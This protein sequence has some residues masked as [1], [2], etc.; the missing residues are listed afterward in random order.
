MDGRRP[1][2]GS[3]EPLG[4]GPGEAG[5][6]A[7]ILVFVTV[8]IDL[9]GFGIVLPLLPFYATDLGAGPGEVGLIIASFSAMQFVFAPVWGRLSDRFGRRP[10][11]LVGL[12]GS[13][14]SYVIFGLAETVAVLLLSRVAGGVMGANVA[15]AQAYVADATTGERRARGMGMIGAAFGIGF[16]LGPAL[17]GV[18]SRWGYAVPGFA[19]AGLSLVAAAVATVALPES[20]PPERRVEGGARGTAALAAA[21]ERGR[22]LLQAV[23]RPALRDPIGAAFVGTLGFAAF[24]TAFPLLLQGPMGMSSVDAGWMFAFLGLVSATVQGG[25][26]GATV[27]RFGERRV[28]WGGAWLLS[29]G[30]VAVSAAGGVA[31]VLL[32]LALIGVG[33]GYMTPSL[34][35]LVSRRAHPR[36]QGGTLG[37]NQSAG[38]LARVIGPLAGGWAFGALGPTRE[39]LATGAVVALAA[40]WIGTIGDDPEAAAAD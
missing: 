26:L 28:A 32:A 23:G 38:S 1:I 31:S 18:L 8:V 29:V 4:S 17:G 16:V 6:T 7:L 14:V 33:F 12:V 20:L 5:R 30:L 10:V 37:I 24:T 19:A 25:L 15:V 21:V 9:I 27:D 13:G 3:T 2:T 34:Q 36:D 22:R 40:L 35:S 39:F 11:L